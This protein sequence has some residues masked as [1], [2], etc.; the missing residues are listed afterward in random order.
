VVERKS[1]KRKLT[2]DNATVITTKEILLDNK[3]AKVSELLGEEIAISHA[4][5]EKYNEDEMEFVMQEHR[6]Q[7]H[8]EKQLNALACP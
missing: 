4:T 1:R 6:Q 7:A 2:L 5:I 3:K 8:V